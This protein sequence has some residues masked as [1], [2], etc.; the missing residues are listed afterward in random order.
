[1]KNIQRYYT[2]L[3]SIAFLLFTL[4][5]FT[6]KK[7]EVVF[8]EIILNL[9]GAGPTIEV[10]F[11]AGPEHNHPMMAV[12]IEDEKG[13][14]IQTL[15]V[16]ESVAKGYFKHAD[17]SDGEWTSGTLVRPASLPVWAHKRDIKNDLG[18]YMPTR[19]NP[20]PDAYTGATP[21]GDFLLKTK[22]DDALPQQFRLIF[23]INQSWDWNEY[24]TNN[25]F[26]DDEDYKTSSQPSLVYAVD[27]DLENREEAYE[28]IAVGHGHYSGK[29][30]EIYYDL[31][32]MTTALEITKDVSVVVKFQ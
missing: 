31:D 8:E 13:N 27:I 26:P 24:W 2:T 21:A 6:Q 19:E 25:K 5:G 20:V 10:S 11:N 7:N 30:G 15:F 18:N 29:N 1:M 4:S 3:A 14:Y 9:N 16:N 23:E 17:K 22:T 28:L 32:N 12:W